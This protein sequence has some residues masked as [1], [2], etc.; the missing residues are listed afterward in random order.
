[1][2]TGDRGGTRQSRYIINKSILVTEQFILKKNWGVGGEG[3]QS[4]GKLT[5]GG[6]AVKKQTL[7]EFSISPDLYMHNESFFFLYMNLFLFL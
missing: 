4:E 7:R 1:M 2:C 5:L 6:I 3:R